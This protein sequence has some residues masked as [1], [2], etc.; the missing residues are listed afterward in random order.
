[1]INLL[2]LFLKFLY[3]GFLA[4]GGGLATIPII[5]QLMVDPGIITEQEF[6]NMIAISQATPGPFGL[7][8][9]TFVGFN[10][11]GLTGA[12][13]TSIAIILPSVICVSILAKIFSKVKDNKYVLGA[14]KALRAAI[15]GIIVI[16]VVKLFK[17]TLFILPEGFVANTI[18]EYKNYLNYI[19]LKAVIATIIFYIAV[20]K[21][22]KSPVVYILLGGIVGA[23]F[24]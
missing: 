3:T 1:M 21:F 2:S 14:M 12:I 17:N 7:N 23:L 24:F 16:A 20:V 22:K 4:F 19:D 11:S 8:I 18:F 9:A 10:D 5:F 6:Y 13:V 15:T